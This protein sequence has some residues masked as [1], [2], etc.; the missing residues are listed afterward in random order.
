MQTV[1]FVLSSNKIDAIFTRHKDVIYMLHSLHKSKIDIY[2]F[3]WGELFFV[4]SLSFNASK[5]KI[6]GKDLKY[7][8]NEKIEQ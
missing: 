2:S 6:K 1:S 8:V 3:S 7:C 5:K 4:Q